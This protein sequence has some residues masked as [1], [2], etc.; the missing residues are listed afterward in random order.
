M[1]TWGSGSLGAIE[2][3]LRALREAR[4]QEPGTSSAAVKGTP[5]L[6]Y[7][8]VIPT[9]AYTQTRPPQNYV[10]E[11]IQAYLSQPY[12]IENIPTEFER[13]GRITYDMRPVKTDFPDDSLIGQ[14]GITMSKV[15]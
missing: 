14:P 7:P 15:P 5:I 11:Q 9:D 12:T 4:N 13:F 10:D 2:Q 1:D 8:G 6:Q 3:R